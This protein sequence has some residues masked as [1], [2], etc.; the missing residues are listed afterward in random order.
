[1]KKIYSLHLINQDKDLN[2]LERSFEIKLAVQDILN[3][4]VNKKSYKNVTYI[5]ILSINKHSLDL[6]VLETDT[7]WHKAIGNILANKYSMRPYCNP[8]NE[9]EMFKWILNE[10]ID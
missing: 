1:M 7:K 4:G 8:K 6:E 5:K 10:I 9:H 3:G 2:L